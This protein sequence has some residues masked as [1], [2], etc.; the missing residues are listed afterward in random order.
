MPPHL[1]VWQHVFCPYDPA[2]AK[3]SK[4]PQARGLHGAQLR[5]DLCSAAACGLESGAGGLE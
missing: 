3:T 4:C 1:Q 5:P 2:R